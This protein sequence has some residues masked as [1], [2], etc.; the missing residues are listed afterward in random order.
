[1]KGGVGPGLFRKRIQEKKKELI[2]QKM[3]REGDTSYSKTKRLESRIK[4]LLSSIWEKEKSSLKSLTRGVQRNG[5]R[6]LFH[7]LTRKGERKPK[8]SL[9]TS[10][11]PRL[12]K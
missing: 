10:S 6:R 4:I 3:N 12:R 5:G 11:K 8:G 7:V 9:D 2:Y 1:M